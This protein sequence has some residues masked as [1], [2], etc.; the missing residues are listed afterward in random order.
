MPT[1][2]TQIEVEKI[3]MKN[4]VTQTP[5]SALEC[6]YC[7]NR[8]EEFNEQNETDKKEINK[9]K[10]KKKKRR[11][12]KMTISMNDSDSDIQMT[13]RC[14]DYVDQIIEEINACSTTYPDAVQVVSKPTE[15]T[16]GEVDIFIENCYLDLERLFI[17]LHVKFPF[18]YPDEPLQLKIL[19]NSK[20]F[21]D[22]PKLEQELINLANLL[23]RA[24]EASLLGIANK[25]DMD[26]QHREVQLEAARNRKNLFEL[27]QEE[28]KRKSKKI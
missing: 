26:I 17:K 23:S 1:K 9:S 27:T 10:R 24:G 3:R 6:L 19:E 11:K 14:L 21:A 7:K 28:Q 13:T 2:S 18:G 25:M 4:G 20:N 15:Q 5:D 8:K 22:L 16:E 12:R